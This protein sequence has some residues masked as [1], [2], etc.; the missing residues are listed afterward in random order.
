LPAPEGAYFWLFVWF[1]GTILRADVGLGDCA[2][3]LCGV[4]VLGYRD[5]APAA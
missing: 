3:R 5:L 4:V 1:R 2:Y